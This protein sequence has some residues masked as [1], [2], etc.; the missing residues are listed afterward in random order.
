MGAMLVKVLCVACGLSI[1]L[2]RALRLCSI[3]LHHV[4]EVI[5]FAGASGGLRVRRILLGVAAIA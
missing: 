5:G 2:R 3:N 4:V 1:T